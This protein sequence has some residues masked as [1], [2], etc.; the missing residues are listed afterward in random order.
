MRNWAKFWYITGAALS[1]L[2]PTRGLQMGSW[3]N[4][5]KPPKGGSSHQSQL[6]QMRLEYLLKNLFIC[7]CAGSWLL[8][9]GF[10]QLKPVGAPLQ[11]R[12][13]SFLWHCSCCSAPALGRM[14]SV[15]GHRLGCPMESPQT[16][17]RTRVPCTAGRFLTTGPPG[18]SKN[19]I[20]SVPSLEVPLESK[21]LFSTVRNIY[22]L[23]LVT[24]TKYLC[25]QKP[26][27][28]QSLIDKLL[29]LLP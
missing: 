29:G 9:M 14:G 7:G 26:A 2:N 20:P 10:L 28:L 17:E 1:T 27:T 11:V 19:K 12:C 5:Q 6:F 18:K 13:T 21:W 8:H 16:T 24:A 22:C 23:S 4:W 3:K 25:G 15:V